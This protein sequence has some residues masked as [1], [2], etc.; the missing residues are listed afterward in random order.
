MPEDATNQTA[1]L[2]KRGAQLL[3]QGDPEAA[4]LH[5]QQAL[6]ANP[7]DGLAFYNAGVACHALEDY[8]KAAENYREAIQ[9]L[10][11]LTAAYHNLAQA[12][13]RLD[14]LSEAIDA[15]Q[16]ALRLDAEDFNSAYNLSLIYRM[17]GRDQEAVGAIQTAI[18][19][20]P[21]SAGAFCVLGMIYHEQDRF[22]EAHVSLEQ[23]L[24]IQPRFSEALY[25]RGIVYQKTGQFER[26]L[27][28]YK[29]AML[30]DP[31]FAP[32]RWLYHLSLP[33]VYDSAGD[34]EIHRIAFNA[35][36]E[37]LIESTPLANDRQKAFALKGIQTTTNFF[38]QYQGRNDLEVQKTYGGFVRNIMAANFPKWS[39]EKSMP[40]PMPGGRLRIGYVSTFMYHHTVGT[41]LSGWL[42]SHTS[43]D[44]DIRG[45][46]VGKK[47]DDLTRHL[48]RL[49]RRF[50]FFGGKLEA[51]AHQIYSDD[52]HILIYTDIGMDPMT[53]QLAALRL[54]PVQCKA[55]GHPVTTGLPT[56]DYYL[57][58]EL[59]EPPGADAFY[60]ESL[61]R[62]PN[63]A[64]CYRPPMMPEQPKTRAEL[65]LPGDRFIYLSTQS[66]FKYLPQHDDIYP[67]IAK[68]VP[69]ACFVFLRH[70]SESVTGRF[71]QR[72]QRA[73]SEFGLEA[74]TYCHFSSRLNFSDFISLNLS[75]DLL[76][77]SLEWSGGK[78]TL[79]ALSCGLPVVTLPGRFMR[80]RHAYAM[81]RRMTVTDT[82][83]VDKAD[84]CNIAV[85]LAKDPVF[86][87]SIKAQIKENRSKL[88]HDRT[89]M[90]AL[91]RFY[92]EVVARYP[93]RGS[94]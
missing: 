45:Y 13:T 41:F 80:G 66:I 84:Y 26:A 85:K 79:E 10:P 15:Y 34:I 82:I 56:I 88:Y 30:A 64:L 91:E 22:D 12:C 62:L 21:D 65:G 17:L 68:Q 9:R 4:Y 83:A 72:L 29:K 89:F 73:F 51:A 94:P 1:D 93:E 52:L 53:T 60:S 40:P 61:I 2:N 27:E 33:M 46:H 75:A 5:F 31:D 87:A 57:S 25:Q 67:M 86:L 54:A 6:S 49:C 43:S 35:R 69:D 39:A 71:R 32:A 70:Q 24:R 76:L 14:H 44:F 55:W 19:M 90:R 48:Q 16:M 58:S 63:L 81:L 7:N 23:A 8:G 36:L 37:A 77:D 28:H 38:L 74:D 20:N 59:M 92:R 50:H 18:R 78:T 47:Q 3:N 11:N 42:E